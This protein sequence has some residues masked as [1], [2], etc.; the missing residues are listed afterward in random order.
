MSKRSGSL[1][2]STSEA[3]SVVEETDQII[4][5]SMLM[6]K[7]PKGFTG[8]KAWQL[9]YFALYEEKLVYK[10]DDKPQSPILGN[11]YSNIFFSSIFVI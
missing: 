2:R 6:K 11:I 8:M 1:D 7:S 5:C 10:R 3:L 9:R 4:L